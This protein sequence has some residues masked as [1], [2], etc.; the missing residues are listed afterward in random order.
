MRRLPL[1]EKGRQRLEDAHPP[2]V[3]LRAAGGQPPAQFFGGDPDRSTHGSVAGMLPGL[4]QPGRPPR[5]FRSPFHELVPGL[6][7]LVCP[8]TMKLA[9]ALPQ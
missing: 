4:G 7:G 5:A 6:Q 8:A 3:Q 2:P 1:D 9:G